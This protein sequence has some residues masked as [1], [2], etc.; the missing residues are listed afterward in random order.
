MKES[1]KGKIS[2]IIGASL[3]FLTMY[4]RVYKKLPTPG[5]LN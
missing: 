3:C 5:S 2:Q 1:I 4:R